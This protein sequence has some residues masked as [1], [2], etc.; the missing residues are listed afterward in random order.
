MQCCNMK[1]DYRYI[2]L[3]TQEA[4]WADFL[5]NTYNVRILQASSKSV[6]IAIRW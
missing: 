5:V 6:S 2:P 1:Y 3:F 4:L